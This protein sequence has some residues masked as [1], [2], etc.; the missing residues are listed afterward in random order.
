MVP[1]IPND[2]DFF[3]SDENAVQDQVILISLH[4]VEDKDAKILL[5]IR[6]HSS[7]NMA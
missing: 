2:C 1:H 4:A 3:V 5:N 6:K 7:D